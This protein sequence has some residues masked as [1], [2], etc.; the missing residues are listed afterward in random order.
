[1]RRRSIYEARALREHILQG[2][3]CQVFTCAS[4]N[5]ICETDTPQKVDHGADQKAMP[6]ITLN[7]FSRYKLST[8]EKTAMHRFEQPLCA[9]HRLG[10]YSQSSPDNINYNRRLLRALRHNNSI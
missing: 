1:M 2:F 5:V 7:C 3:S 9:F 10:V 4:R 8:C 6:F